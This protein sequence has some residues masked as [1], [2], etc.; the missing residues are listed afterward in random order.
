MQTPIHAFANCKHHSVM[1]NYKYTLEPY[2]GMNSRYTCPECGK[3]KVFSRY[4]DIETG[5][6]LA[7]HVG[8]CS[9]ESKCGNHYKPKQYFEDN[10]LSID[11]PKPYFKKAIQ[12]PIVKP[13]SFIPFNTFKS[14]LSGYEQNNFVK[15]LISLFGF[16]I[17]TDLI[18]K[19]YI[20][21]SNHWQ[22]ANV[23]WQ[24]D[25]KGKV[26]TGKIMLYSP[27][28]GKR[29]KE[30]Y[31]HIN[32]VHSVNK[33]AEFNLQ[34]CLFGEHLINQSN[35]K[36]I[37][38]VESEKTAIIA[39]VYLPM[40]SWLAVGSLTNLTFDKC[41]VLQG[42]KV[43]LFPDLNGFEK[44]SNKAKE[45]STLASFTI[46]DLL[47][48]KA[49]ATE[50]Q[51]GLDLADYLIRFD[52]RQFIEQ[53]P[54]EPVETIFE[55][56]LNLNPQGGTFKHEQQV[57]EVWQKASLQLLAHSIKKDIEEP[58]PNSIK[59]SI[60]PKINHSEPIQE[61]IKY[62]TTVQLPA[63]A[64]QLNAAEKICN[65]ALFVDTHLQHLQA[66]AGRAICE[67]FINRLTTL[68]TILQ[69]GKA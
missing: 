63:T 8:K 35:S 68:K 61:L 13:V 48:R 12:Q 52:Y 25:A 55:N 2:K 46:S 31:N 21:S 38:I 18:S 24:V 57:F 4:I 43:V 19:Y 50:K 60:E 42:C 51:Q 49:T 7:D 23:F 64:I 44:W 34:Q 36:S 26:R 53:A 59:K 14:S 16:E 65:V 54:A 28:T 40:F 56:W 5:E 10:S 29:V 3:Q 62:F 32:W 17:T 58:V 6:Q 41:K 9:R 69:H 33:Q 37:A 22:G 15:Y 67:P 20:G 1:S 11:K 30:P 47:E 27:T 66:N 45:L 39:S